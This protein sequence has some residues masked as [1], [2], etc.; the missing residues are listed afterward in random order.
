MPPIVAPTLAALSC[1]LYLAYE[2]AMAFDCAVSKSDGILGSPKIRSALTTRLYVPAGVNVPSARPPLQSVKGGGVFRDCHESSNRTAL[3]FVRRK[4][5]T[6]GEPKIM[7]TLMDTKFVAV[8]F[9][10]MAVVFPCFGRTKG[11]LGDARFP[12]ASVTVYV[13]QDPETLHGAGHTLVE[14]GELASVGGVEG[15]VAGP[16]THRPPGPGRWDHKTPGSA[17]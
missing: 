15:D 12:V 11:W 13:L 8:A 4:H 10:G 6:R 1:S 14:D 9:A 5:R 7:L 17:G 2:M 3:E 16:D